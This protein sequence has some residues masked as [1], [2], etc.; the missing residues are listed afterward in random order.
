MKV[1]IWSDFACPFCYIGK[2]YY[3]R[4]LEQFPHREQI[5]TQYKSFELDP[6]E[7]QKRP[8]IESLAEKYGTSVQ[9]AKEM[10]SGVASRAKEAGLTFNFEHMMTI[11]SLD[12]HRIVHY[13]ETVGKSKELVEALFYAYF[14]ENKD[15]SDRQVLISIAESVQL[16]VTEVLEDEQKYKA[17]VRA[18]EFEA[19][20]LGVR[21]VPF[22]VVDRK[23]AI[24]GAQPVSVFVDTLNKAWS[25]RS[26]GL[27][28]VEAD[29]D[30]S[31]GPDGCKV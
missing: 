10:T 24:S 14:T 23:Y 11:N 27:Q 13:A 20:Q 29:G 31:C 15:L 26:S 28:H 6:N 22:F 1:E 2:T 17:Q 4:A 18:D 12:A 9:Q 21:G 16:Q 25:E 30:D 8:T 7:S 5:V 19:Q 3:E